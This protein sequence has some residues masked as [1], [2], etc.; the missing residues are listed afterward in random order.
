[1]SLIDYLNGVACAYTIWYHEVPDADYMATVPC[2]PNVCG[3][4]DMYD[5]LWMEQQVLAEIESDTRLLL[6]QSGI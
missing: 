2:D 5:E 1:M 4:C 3:M 6:E